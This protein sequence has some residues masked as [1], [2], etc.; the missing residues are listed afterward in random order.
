VALAG[1]EVLDKLTWDATVTSIELYILV[2]YS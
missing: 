2:I 1:K